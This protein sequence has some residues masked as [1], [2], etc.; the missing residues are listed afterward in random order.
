LFDAGYD[1]VAVADQNEAIKAMQGE[2]TGGIKL[3]MTD[4]VANGTVNG[5]ELEAAAGLK[6]QHPGL[7]TLFISGHSNIPTL[8]RKNKVKDAGFLQRPFMGTDL[9]K[10]AREMLTKDVA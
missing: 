3:L 10:S 5:I 2:D 9:V 1:V 6:A 8:I 4:I 7:K